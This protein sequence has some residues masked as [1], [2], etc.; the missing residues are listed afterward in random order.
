MN[1]FIKY[2]KRKILIQIF[3]F[4]NSFWV[5]SS[6]FKFPCISAL[7]LQIILSSHFR[8]LNAWANGKCSMAFYEIR[9]LLVPP[10][11]FHSPYLFPA[12]FV[13]ILSHF[14]QSKVLLNSIPINSTA[15]NQLYFNLNLFHSA[16]VDIH[17]CLCEIHAH[18]IVLILFSV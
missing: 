7:A 14:S 11:D 5:S 15:L 8:L 9:I 4:C 17:Y 10:L 3:H 1:K 6:L 12:Y 18:N 2:I 16:S 13:N